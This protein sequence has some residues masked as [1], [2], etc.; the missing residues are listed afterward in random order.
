MPSKTEDIETA[1]TMV[2]K[3]GEEITLA[4][5]DRRLYDGYPALADIDRR[6]IGAAI[7]HLLF[8]GKLLAEDLHATYTESFQVR[9][10]A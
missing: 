4:E 7:S 10:P 1:I 2:I 8:T 5:L 9:R 3:P 6:W